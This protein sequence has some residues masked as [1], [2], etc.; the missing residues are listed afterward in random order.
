ML[1]LDDN[2]CCCFLDIIHLVFE[3][4]CPTDLVL[5][6]WVRLTGKQAFNICLS[7]HPWQWEGKHAASHFAFMGSCL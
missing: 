5:F 3:T 4:K 1:R 7:F 2:L 6:D